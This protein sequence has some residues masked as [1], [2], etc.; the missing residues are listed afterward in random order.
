MTDDFTR[1]SSLAGVRYGAIDAKR[2]SKAGPS[3]AVVILGLADVPEAGDILRVVAD[4]KVARTQVESRKNEQAA[5]DGAG[6]GRATLEDLY[7]QIQA[8]Q[9]KELR[10][11]LKADVSGSLGAISHALA[12]LGSDEVKINVLLEAAGDPFTLR[13]RLHDD[14]HRAEPVERVHESLA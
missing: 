8:G 2:V 11:I 7:S 9:A 14:P 1:P 5:R 12:Q 6:A 3:S 13:P 4:E 10:I